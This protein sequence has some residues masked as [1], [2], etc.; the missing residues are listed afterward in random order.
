MHAPL[1]VAGNLIPYKE[2]AQTAPIIVRH[3]N[4]TAIE[5]F[6]N[7]ADKISNIT[8]LIFNEAHILYSPNGINPIQRLEEKGIL[9]DII[10]GCLDISLYS[11]QIHEFN[12]KFT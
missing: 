10:D 4:P 12:P 8:N 1:D 7:L 6:G 2:G 3:I 9:D 11:Y 5:M